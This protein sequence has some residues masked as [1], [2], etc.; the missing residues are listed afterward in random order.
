MDVVFTLRTEEGELKL[1][2]REENE[3]KFVCDVFEGTK[4]AGKIA[5]GFDG[6]GKISNIENLGIDTRKYEKIRNML[7]E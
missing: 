3:Q 4:P 2:C 1:K 7:V 6:N 5:I